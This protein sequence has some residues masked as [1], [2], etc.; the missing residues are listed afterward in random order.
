MWPVT[1]LSQETTSFTKK[2]QVITKKIP[3][4]S[5]NQAIIGTLRPKLE[6]Y[7]YVFNLPWINTKTKN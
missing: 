1:I 4:S 5:S 6:L 2:T 3:S 7:K